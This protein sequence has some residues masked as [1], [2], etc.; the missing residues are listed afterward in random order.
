MT[1]EQAILQLSQRADYAQKKADTPDKRRKAKEYVQEVNCIIEYYNE[2]ESTGEKL[3]RVCSTLQILS[4]YLGLDSY[5]H[6]ELLHIPPDYLQQRLRYYYSTPL[7]ALKDAIN[8]YHELQ[9]SY[10]YLQTINNK[11]LI[12]LIEEDIRELTL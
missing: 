6:D 12:A 1:T 10:K 3:K 8:D 5:L 4:E 9:E 7:Q 11:E 2:T